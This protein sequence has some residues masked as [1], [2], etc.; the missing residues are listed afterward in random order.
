MFTLLASLLLSS[1]ASAH[2]PVLLLPVEGAPIAGHFLSQSE[3]SRAVYTELSSPGDLFF[4]SFLQKPEEP[5]MISLFAPKCAAI[6]QYETFQPSV[7]VLRG[8]APWKN[9]GESSEQYLARLEGM[10]VIKVESKFK[11]GQRPAYDEE[12]AKQTLW[13]GGEWKGTL[14]AGLYTLVAFDPAGKSGN[15]VIGLN[16]KESWSIDLLNYAGKVVPKI[17]Q[18]L[19]SPKGFSGHLKLAR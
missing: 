2:V 1:A 6:P 12:H 13:V 7:L 11:K 8:E 14:E 19:C 10:A 3:I 5:V 9:E 16:E 18:R 15:F 4:A 17:N